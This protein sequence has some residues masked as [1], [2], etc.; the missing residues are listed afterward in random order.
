M[1]TDPA[2]IGLLCDVRTYLSDNI[3]VQLQRA[4]RE[5]LHAIASQK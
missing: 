1:L 2:G 3:E 4:E 5:Q